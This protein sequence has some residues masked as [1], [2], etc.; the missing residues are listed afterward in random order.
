[1]VWFGLEGSKFKT[2]KNIKTFL[3]SIS[4]WLFSA[5]M[6]INQAG[7]G[8]EILCGG[9]VEILHESQHQ[10][11]AEFL[12]VPVPAKGQSE[13][14]I[15]ISHRKWTIKDFVSR[16]FRTGEITKGYSTFFQNCK[17]FAV[18]LFN[19]YSPFEADDSQF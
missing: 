17:D 5:M 13:D 8:V 12:Y 7:C 14:F 3:C 16:I 18:R 9:D 11:D 10:P 1:M 15:D 4:F 6:F 2:A 19:Y